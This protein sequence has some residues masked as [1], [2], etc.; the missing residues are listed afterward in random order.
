MWPF[1]QPHCLSAFNSLVRQKLLLCISVRDRRG[2]ARGPQRA[3]RSL[4]KEAPD[5]RLQGARQ[6]AAIPRTAPPYPRG[7]AACPN[8]SPVPAPPEQ[9][10][11]GEITMLC[12]PCR[13]TP[14][15]H[16]GGRAWTGLGTSVGNT[17]FAMSG[18]QEKHSG[19]LSSVGSPSPKTYLEVQPWYFQGTAKLKQ[20]SDLSCT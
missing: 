3:A 17:G 19:E 8:F 16:W 6:R 9:V 5:G 4:L 13:R 14:P 18:L 12:T 11:P 1:F 20:N 10:S 15:G 2:E 7:A